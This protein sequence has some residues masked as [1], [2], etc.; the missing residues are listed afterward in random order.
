MHAVG[1]HHEPISGE[2][3]VA[4]EPLRGRVDRELLS[5]LEAQRIELGTEQPDGVVLVD[6]LLRLVRSGGKRL[7]P[8]LCYWGFRAAG[9]AD[10]ERIVRAAAALEL[11][12]TFALVHDDVMDRSP[13]RRGV[14]TTHERFTQAPAGDREAAQIGASIA[15][16]VGD[17][18]AVLADRLFGAAGFDGDVLAAARARYDRMRVEMAVGQL[19]DLSSRS[20]DE[21]LADRISS[22][23]TGSYTFEGPLQIGALLAG[24]GVDVLAV[25]SAYGR[26]LGEAFQLSDDLFGVLAGEDDLGQA[27]PSWIRARAR[28]VLDPERFARLE[29][30][31]AAEARAM[32]AEAGVIDA[33]ADHANALVADAVTALDDA[34]LA[35]EPA[36]ALREIAKLVQVRP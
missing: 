26:P 4:A 27:R 10:D 12:H 19:L 6:E 20:A 15:I 9:G 35:P 24:G 13:T 33:A 17:F 1:G 30:A 14:Q 25:L 18:A 16:L 7:R 32:L 28:E 29:Q 23:K 31:S 8:A 34:V 3:A 36:E 11:L 2:A 5:F 22:L 21:R